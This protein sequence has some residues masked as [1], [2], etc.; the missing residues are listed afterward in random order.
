MVADTF[1]EPAASVFT[2]RIFL[3]KTEKRTWAPTG[4]I[5]WTRQLP[6]GPG[7]MKMNQAGGINAKT[8]VDA[9]LKMP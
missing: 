2:G 3:R 1:V 6:N 4:I 9:S 7:S 8:R 5:A